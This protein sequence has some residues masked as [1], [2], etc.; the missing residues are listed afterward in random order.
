MSLDDAVLN[1]RHIF[2]HGKVWHYA[3]KDS[4][5]KLCKYNRVLALFVDEIFQL[6]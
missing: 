5:D 1:S 2:D 3:D 6:Y 4:D